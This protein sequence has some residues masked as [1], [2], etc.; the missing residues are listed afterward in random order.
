MPGTRLADKTDILHQFSLIIV[1][2]PFLQFKMATPFAVIQELTSVIHYGM[3]EYLPQLD[4]IIVDGYVNYAALQ[5]VQDVLIERERYDIL[6]V[7]HQ[8]MTG[9]IIVEPKKN[10]LDSSQA[11]PGLFLLN[12][13]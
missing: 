11:T 3:N 6:E 12:I 2:L 7:L 13:Q 8:T 1:A 5:R 9:K 10:Y 4:V